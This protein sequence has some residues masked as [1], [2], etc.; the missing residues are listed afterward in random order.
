MNARKYALFIFTFIA[1]VSGMFSLIMNNPLS[2]DEHMYIS[3][4]VLIQNNALYKDFAYLQMPYLPVFYGIVY[5]L[6]GTSYYLLWGRMFTFIFM[7]LSGLLIFLIAHKITNSLFV[8]T[9]S[10]VL[11]VCNELIVN[12]MPFSWNHVVPITFSLLAFYLFISGISKV[13]INIL[14][15]FLGGISIGVAI[16]TKLTYAVMP[17][18]F[19]VIVFLFPRSFT[20]KKKIV[21]IFLPLI[22]GLSVGLL[23]ILF[24]LQKTTLDVFLF[25][26]LGYHLTNTI[27]RNSTGFT[28]GMSVVS[29]MKF[30]WETFA[31]PSNVSLFVVISF[32]FLNL[33][34]EM[35]EKVIN[36]KQIFPMEALFSIFLIF[37]SLVTAFQMTPL[38][39]SYF[40]MA[41]PF[42]IIL[43][44]CGY[45]SL[46][47]AK[48]PAVRVLLIC[49]IIIISIFGGVR[50]FS[51]I[52]NIL[53]IDRW[54]GISVH[55]TAE[56]IKRFT[57]VIKK[58]DRV[59]TLDPVYVVE[60][61]LPIYKE[62]VTGSFLYRVG[63]LISEKKRAQYIGTSQKSLHSLFDIDPPKAIYV[64][65]D[66]DL[67]LPFIEYAETHDFTKID[68]G[69]KRGILY[70]RKDN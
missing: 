6:T 28:T 35:K 15:L 44:C 50:L 51:Q 25:N 65:F 66:G 21:T 7:V 3:A 38:L 54:T 59:A 10:V 11:L 9:A 13:P 53:N 34:S 17:L 52:H 26:N 43:I 58:G 47:N 60:A 69:L 22:A 31:Y 12:L 36:L 5:K 61:N 42:A 2:H 32:I 24:V 30:S 1:V 20:F 33:F 29:K 70:V 14:F 4:G 46:S 18:A 8:S 37:I 41:I 48:R 27:W 45:A 67:E 55:H 63:D 19:F 57:G 16:G 62:L 64:R 49:F 40:A 56:Q 68:N 39:P 23:P